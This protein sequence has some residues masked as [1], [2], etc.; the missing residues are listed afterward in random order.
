MSRFQGILVEEQEVPT[1]KAVI[2]PE[3]LAAP[4]F[5]GIAVEEEPISAIQP[6]FRTPEGRV[7]FREDVEDELPVGISPKVEDLLPETLKFATLDA[8]IEISPKV[9]A[10]LVGMGHMMT[11]VYRGIKQ[12]AGVDEEEMAYS[13]KAMKALYADPE[14]GAYITT[15]AV[16]GALVE[17]V[18]LMMPAIKGAG[19][20]KGAAKAAGIGATFGTL[21][22]VD[23]EEGR[24]RVGNA[25]LGGTV[26]GTIGAVTR[27]VPKGWAA[28]H[29]NRADKFLDGLEDDWAALIANDIPHDAVGRIIRQQDPN[30]GDKIVN[31]MK[32]TGRAPNTFMS[33]EE[34]LAH[35]DY[36]KTFV[37]QRDLPLAKSTE[38]LLGIVSTRIKK[39]SA[40]VFNRVRQY[41]M[42]VH[43]KTHEYL[44]QVKPFLQD[45]RGLKGEDAAIVNRALLNGDFSVVDEVIGKRLGQA[46]LDNFDTAKKVLNELGDNLTDMGRIDGKIENYFPRYIK[47]VGKLKRALGSDQRGSIEKALSEA[48]T[49]ALK[50]GYPL[51]PQEENDI[52]NRI[53]R[54]LPY[55][56]AGGPGFTKVRKISKIDVELMNHYIDPKLSLDSYIRSAVTDMEKA[57]FFGKDLSLSGGFFDPG[58]SVGKY[59]KSDTYTGKFTADEER[60]LAELLHLRFSVGEKS[61]I[62]SIQRTKNILYATLLGNPISAA[63]QLGDVG[64]SIYKN[65]LKDSLVAVAKTLT[66]KTEV[67]IKDFGLVDALA[68][69]FAGTDITAKFLHKSMRFGG[70]EAV[71]R[72]GKSTIINSALSKYKKL[73]LTE[74]GVASIAKKYRNVYGDEFNPLVKDLIKGDITDNV[75]LLLWHELADVQ[76]ISLSE[77]PKKYLQAPNGRILYMLKTFMLK[78]F[79]IVRQDSYDL[80]RNGQVKE[81]LGNLAKY[82]IILG[83]TNAGAGYVKDWM[84]G[85]DVEV[86]MPDD[87]VENFFKVFGWSE[88]QTERIKEGKVGETL[89]DL[90]APPIDIFDSI[91]ENPKELVKAM[92][93]IGKLYYNWFMGGIEEEQEK[94]IKRKEKEFLKDYTEE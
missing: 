6:R 17:P 52:I 88:F 23:E 86:D 44:T 83:T 41:D 58:T 8:G 75:K 27:A 18:G 84:R 46:G 28:L 16:I 2:A 70:F 30:I 77:V 68:E 1:T 40:P 81:G 22:Y 7:P 3:P 72:F 29:R 91:K 20:L 4:R 21:G 32:R 43:V 19:I 80:I 36:K 90:V 48:N 34:A 35:M 53:I 9:S 14:L 69:E 66:G 92:P 47:D 89:V 61:P 10:T 49:S 65:G 74:E 12:I 57:K 56:G 55:K 94:L 37:K 59:L 87:A 45:I 60:E 42:D 51:S 82:G 33:K 26:G 78:Q 31:A 11:D 62:K 39:L 54:G 64:I 5:K 93:I 13:Q 25:I 63:T 24:T 73:A 50:R 67:K 85:R 79:D 71:D 38:S 15:G 76:P